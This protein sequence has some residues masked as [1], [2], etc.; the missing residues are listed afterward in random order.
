[1]PL[2]EHNFNLIELGPRGTGKP[3]VYQEVSPYV[4]LLTGPITVANLFYNIGTKPKSSTT[5]SRL[6]STS[7]RGT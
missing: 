1:L 4:I 6:A 7:T 3:Y 5:T 2:C